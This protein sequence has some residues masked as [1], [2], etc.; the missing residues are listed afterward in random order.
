LFIGGK[1]TVFFYLLHSIF[2]PTSKKVTRDG[3][4]KKNQIKYSIRDSQ[5][6]FFV[7]KNTIGEIEER[8]LYLGNE[9]MPIQPFILLV[10][11]PLNH[12]E[13]IVY[14]D[15]IRYKMFNILSAI[16]ICFKIFHLFNL[17]YLSA[18]S[19]VWTFIQKYF[20]CFNTKYDKSYHTLGQFLS[21]I[22]N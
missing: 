14:F 17:E 9:K 5:E 21:D 12:R 13:I 18:S 22:Q 2:V 6:T 19:I 1:N 10:G 3:N 8:I 7:F 16:D 11:T 15:S 20:Y 4:G